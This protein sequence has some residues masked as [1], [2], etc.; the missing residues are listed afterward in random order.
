MKYDHTGES[1]AETI[2][3]VLRKFNIG[4]QLG[5]LVADKAD[6]ND[7]AIG[8]ILR[9]IRPDLTM[10]GRRSH[11]LGHIINSAAKA[12]LFGNIVEAFEAVTEG[13]DE[14]TAPLDSEAMKKAQ[15][16]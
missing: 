9:A 2:V 4:P 5:V 6:S 3:P 13:V 7:T 11:C 1:I 12:F 16:A 10:K 15:A 14:A 8:A